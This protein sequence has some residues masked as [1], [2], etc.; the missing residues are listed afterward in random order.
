MPDGTKATES[1][2]AAIIA[3]LPRL[4]RFCHV[5]GVGVEGLG[6]QRKVHDTTGQHECR[7]R[8]VG[9]GAPGNACERDHAHDRIEQ[10]IY[11]LLIQHSDSL[12][13]KAVLARSTDNTLDNTSKSSD[14]IPTATDRTSKAGWYP[15]CSFAS[16]A[17]RVCVDWKDAGI[18]RA[19]GFPGAGKRA[20]HR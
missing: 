14:R 3:A 12:R 2:R 10:H 15:E 6:H 18:G 1:M 16:P 5:R 9:R 13:H 4:R 17:R 7:R 19:S 11:S 8:H 20:N